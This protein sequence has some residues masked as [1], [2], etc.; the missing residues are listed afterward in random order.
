MTALTP[1]EKVH[2]KGLFGN[3]YKKSQKEIIEISEIHN[4]SI[5]QITQYK[6]SKINLKSLKIEGLEIPTENSCVTSN[7]QTRVLWNAPNTWLILS[8]KENIN[9][10]LKKNFEI[11][12]F[13]ITDISHSRAIIQIKGPK[14]KEVLKKGSPINFDE[15]KINKCVGTIFNG[16]SVVIDSTSNNPNT[17][18]I[19]TLRSFG[20]SLYHHITDAS[21][22]FGYIGA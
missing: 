15:F 11:T 20:E 2:K 13:A 12:D 22:E 16:I 7:A 4:L 8:S 1:L 3:H 18:T 21:L 5:I 14:V 10:D 19:L 17:F 6:R 9:K